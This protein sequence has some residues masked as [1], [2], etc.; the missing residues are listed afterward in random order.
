MDEN[1]HS[2]SWLRK[3]PNVFTPKEASEWWCA[4]RWCPEG[5]SKNEHRRKKNVGKQLAQETGISSGDYHSNFNFESWLFKIW[6]LLWTISG[7]GKHSRLQVAS[8]F[9]YLWGTRKIFLQL[10]PQGGLSSTGGFLDSSKSELPGV[11]LGIHRSI[12]HSFPKHQE[13][14]SYPSCFG[15][16]KRRSIEATGINLAV[17]SFKLVQERGLAKLLCERGR[18]AALSSLFSSAQ[19]MVF[20][21]F[22]WF[23]D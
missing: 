2:P 10:M 12:F 15:T 9:P 21:C 19:G 4:A 8:T 18:Q 3:P 6:V 1:W 23:S 7:F 13:V 11:L 22:A 16:H 5:W 17:H 20:H 14:A